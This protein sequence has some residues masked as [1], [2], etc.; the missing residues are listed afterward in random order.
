ME[1]P[2]EDV[3][4]DIN[5]QLL[6]QGLARRAKQRQPTSEEPIQ[7]EMEE[8]RDGII[9]QEVPFFVYSFEITFICY[10]F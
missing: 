7:L 8:T 9:P 10:S 6:M 5:Q 4:E 2:N 3:S 1:V